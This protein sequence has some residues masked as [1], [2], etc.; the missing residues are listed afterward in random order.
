MHK[1]RI[2]LLEYTGPV[3]KPDRIY[4]PGEG[5][6]L[7]SRRSRVRKRQMRKMSIFPAGPPFPFHLSATISAGATR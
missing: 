5:A 3:A 6:G 4:L 2:A 7:L 1:A